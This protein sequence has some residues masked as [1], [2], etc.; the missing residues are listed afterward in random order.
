ME[1]FIMLACIWMLLYELASFKLG[2]LR[3]TIRLNSLISLSNTLT[4]VQVHNDRK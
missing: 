4:F 3:V 1:M 2:M